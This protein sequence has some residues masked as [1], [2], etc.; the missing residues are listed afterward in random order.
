[1]LFDD[2]E[3]EFM[4]GKPKT[5]KVSQMPAGGAGG[6]G[7]APR[8]AKKAAA[9]EVRGYKMNAQVGSIQ[10]VLQNDHNSSLYRLHLM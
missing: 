3:D 8:A 5:T 7:A 2:L 1:M 6:V 10:P 9:S 4:L